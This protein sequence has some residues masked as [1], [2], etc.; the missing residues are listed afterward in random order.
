MRQLALA[1]VSS[2]MNIWAFTIKRGLTPLEIPAF[3]KLIFNLVIDTQSLFLFTE[4]PAL[5]ELI[6]FL[7]P[8]AV[9]HIPPRHVVSYVL[10][11]LKQGQLMNTSSRWRTTRVTWKRL[12]WT[13]GKM[14]QRFI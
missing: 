6:Q 5:A 12:H 1:A 8:G 4:E 7:Q 10:L 2:S 3:Q 9:E 13:G 11:L 14:C